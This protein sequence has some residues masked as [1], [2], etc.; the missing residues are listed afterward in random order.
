[1]KSLLHALREHSDWVAGAIVLLAVLWMTT[2][3]RVL[4]PV[5]PAPPVAEAPPAAEERSG[6]VA[7]VR[8]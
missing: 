1:M 2:A 7:A 8:R 6:D 5:R 4:M 3:A